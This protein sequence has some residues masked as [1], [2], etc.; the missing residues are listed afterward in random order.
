MPTV[1]DSWHGVTKRTHGLFIPSVPHLAYDFV[2][3]Q[4]FVRKGWLKFGI[5]RKNRQ[6]LMKWCFVAL[7]GKSN[8]LV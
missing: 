7:S 5:L 8:R 4:N 3:P 6:V 2:Y 1:E